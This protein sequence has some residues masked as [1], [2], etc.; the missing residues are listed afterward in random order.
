MEAYT[1]FAVPNV[2]NGQI[3]IDGTK[4]DENYGQVYEVAAGEA[5]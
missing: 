1:Q 4:D 2:H 5:Q 3:K